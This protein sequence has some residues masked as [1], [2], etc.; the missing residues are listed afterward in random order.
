MAQ[1]MSRVYNTQN[2][3]E[4]SETIVSEAT[5]KIGTENWIPANVGQVTV[6][7]R[8]KVGSG[9]IRYKYLSLLVRKWK[10]V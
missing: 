3:Y 9:G 1:P 8:Q 2:A 5:E 10:M 4:F 6:G 7:I